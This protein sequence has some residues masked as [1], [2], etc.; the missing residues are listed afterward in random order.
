M[1][2]QNETSFLGRI[3]EELKHWLRSDWS[4]E[5]VARHWDATED[6]DDINRETYSYFRRFT[7]G[8]KFS[9]LDPGLHVLDFC[10][11]TGNGTIYFHENGKVDSAVCAD[12]SRRMGEICVQRLRE[13]G[14]RDF[15]WKQVLDYDLPFDDRSFDA[16]LCF[17]TIEHFS[18]PER[19]V[20]ELSRVIRP[21]GCMIL[22]TPNI[23]WEPIHALAAIF[24]LHHSEG[25]HRFIRFGRLKAMVEQAGFCIECAETTVLVPG[26]PK[27][28][29][30]LGEWIEARTR[31]WL[32]PIFGLRRIII[33][34]KG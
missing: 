6:Y 31:T 25:P 5:D 11:R 33:A 27:V 20:A 28:L 15:I 21:G 9:Q 29:V 2:S 24:K 34:R 22:T 17:E 7:D 19:L 30:R 10:A 12:V 26:G 1:T 4:F 3:R 32:M 16:I 14:I 23:L 13:A 8:L 18:K